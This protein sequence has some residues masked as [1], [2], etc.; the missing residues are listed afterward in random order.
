MAWIMI[1]HQKPLR[2]LIK[3]GFVYVVRGH[4][5]KEGVNKLK[6]KGYK[7]IGEV[8]VRY[9]GQI[10][11]SVWVVTKDGSKL[12]LDNFVKYS[13]FNSVVEWLSTYKTY[14]P[15]RLYLLELLKLYEKD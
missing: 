5:K 14:T 10:H 12:L 1:S 3:N 4:I 6:C 11:N 8:Y 15:P 2:F 13:G 7:T 9:I